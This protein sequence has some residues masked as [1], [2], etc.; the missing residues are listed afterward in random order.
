M[1]VFGGVLQGYEIEKTGFVGLGQSE[2]LCMGV[3]WVTGR[4]GGSER[5]MEEED[6]AYLLLLF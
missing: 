5:E 1:R 2:E 4:I 3:W 6:R